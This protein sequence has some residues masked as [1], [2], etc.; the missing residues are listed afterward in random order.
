[1]RGTAHILVS[2]LLLAMLASGCS[3]TKN[4]PAGAKLYNK[5]SI[6]FVNKKTVN[7]APIVQSDLL[8]RSRPKGNRKFLGL[9]RIRLWLYAKVK[10]PKKTKSL[11]HW[12]KYTIGEAPVLYNEDDSRKSVLLMEKYMEDNGYFRS[13]ITFDTI[14][15]KKQ[16]TV[17]Y[18][19]T[20]EGQYIVNNIWLPSDT[21]QASKI[22][23]KNYHNMIIRSRQ[24]YSVDKLK[25]ERDKFASIVRDQGFYDF[26]R[27]F[28]YY[29]VD[30]TL[31]SHKVDVYFMVKP[32][33]DTTGHI[34]Y[35]INEV[36]VYPTYSV[37]DTTTHAD[38]IVYDSLRI[39][40]NEKFLR[41]KPLDNAILI[42]TGNTFSTK[43]HSFTINHLLNLGI[44][45]YVNIKY[46]KTGR[47]S[48]NVNVYLT[49]GNTQ[50]YAAELN[51]STTTTNFLGTGGLLS[52]SNHNVFKG[53]ELL[54]LT[55]S[56]NVE[57]QIAKKLSF[58]NTLDINGKA[59]LIFPRFITPFKIKHLSLY[60]I[61]RARFALSDAYQRRIQYYTLNSFL[62]EGGYDWRQTLLIRH[63]LT[64]IS[65]NSI[66]LF[67]TTPAF[68]TILRKNP[69]LRSSFDDVFIIAFNYSFIYNGKTNQFKRL[70]FYFK[71]N[72]DVA[73]NV[74]YGFSKAI[75]P[76]QTTPYHIFGR[77]FAN[78]S[79]FD[80]DG[81]MYYNITKKHSFVVRALAGVA[82]PYGNSAVVPY[83][84][85]FFA[86]GS[87]DVRAYRIRTLG[88][89]SYNNPNNDN[90]IFPD[91]SGDIKMELNAELRL[92]IVK[93]LKAAVFVDAGN[94]W[95]TRKDPTRAGAEFNATRFYKEFA[96][97][98][99][100]GLRL[101]FDFFVIR[102]DASFP[103]RRPELADGRRWVIKD[104]NPGLKTWRQDNLVWNIAIG[105]PF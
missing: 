14:V 48:L 62:F 63:V 93:F 72:A 98:T 78:Y 70:Y 81:R 4:L 51:L 28:I 53:A 104:I 23:A 46:V 77:P 19:V 69:I 88:P 99:G 54:T 12:L 41:K 42:R 61:P 74:F 73:G 94:V 38:T 83:S 44:Y 66:R 80:V 39:I 10:E 97:G 57:T 2:V 30:T 56:V 65:V 32:P 5:S 45:K 34:K 90:T 85:E 105:Y 11:R 36:T 18:S 50:T 26:S 43:N 33:T 13:K 35:Y 25:E 20:T 52:Y 58:I 6:K 92:T 1:M 68:D 29:Y 24:P 31:G 17:T 87:N 101:D 60:F 103:L 91:Q 59:E 79:K 7:A 21:S 37:D 16:V 82:V 76:D 64:P 27:D 102:V 15:R 95:L 55:G 47:D 40:Q 9:F 84:K 8:D 49:P 3:G 96:V 71:G 100:V 22:I 86:G 67:S 89:G 75:H